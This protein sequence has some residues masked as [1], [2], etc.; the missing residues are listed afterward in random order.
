MRI[1]WGRVIVAIVLLVVCG[2]I[3]LG[4][5]ITNLLPQQAE[6]VRDR[7]DQVVPE[8]SF[9]AGSGVKIGDGGGADETAAADRS[10]AASGDLATGAANPPAGVSSAGR[11]DSALPPFKALT[12][13]YTPYMATLA[14]MDAG[15]YMEALGYDLQLHDVYSEAV[16]LDE[17]GQCEAVKSGSYQALAT[18]VDATRKCGDG[19]AVGIPIGQ[20]AGNDAI[21]VK[22]GVETWNDIFEHAVA[23]TGYS[24]S[25]YMACFAS[26]SANQPVK[27]P[28]RY[29]DA[30]AAVDDWINSGAEQNILSVVAWEP[31]VSRA[32]AAVPDSRVI[33]SSKDVRILWDVVEFGAAQAQADPAAF[34]AFTRAYYLALRDLIRDPDAALAKMVAW[35]GEDPDRQALLTTTDPAEFRQQLDSEAFATLRDAG[36]L[37]ENRQSLVNRLDEAAFY[38]Q[39]CN[40]EVPA[41]AD[42]EALILPQFVQTAA[43]DGSLVTP[44]DALV[45][46]EVFQASDFTNAA[47]V[48]DTQ[49]EEARVLFQKGVEIEFL[50][51]R[52]DFRDPAAA[53]AT[54]GEAVRFLRTCQDCV[55]QVQGGAAYPGSRLCPTCTAQQSDELAVSRGQRVHDELRGRFDVPEAQLY[56]VPEPHAPQFPSSDD[57]A[58]LRQDRRTFLT[59][60][61]L[62]GR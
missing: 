21:V 13:A 41:V 57:E 49:I 32:L 20:S 14:H 44:A 38:W 28:L 18:T 3:A 26:H 48:T 12:L 35:A 25:E 9:D 6:G 8:V 37:M 34:E 31:E 2:A 23:F 27:L 39:Y 22:P 29:D 30:A 43:A 19:V 52:T 54:L 62:G 24:V 50:P 11:D 51:N 17:E 46:A 55:L 42:E 4:V 15:G 60:Y 61:Q 36:L 5:M 59:G 1:R 47:A 10:D 16:D 33:L 58:E 7:L 40:V 56:L 53:L 45:S